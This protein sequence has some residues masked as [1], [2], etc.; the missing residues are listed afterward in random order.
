MAWNQGI[1][2]YGYDDNRFLKGAEY[3]ARW[4]LGKEVPFTPWTWW[5]GAPGVW[6]GSET[7]TT[8]S[9]LGR[10]SVRPIWES[11]HNHY[12]KRRGLAAPHVAAIAA[13]ARPEGSGGDY[14]PNSGGFDQLGFGTLTF[15]RD[16]VPAKAVTAS[17]TQAKSVAAA[18]SASGSA[19]AAVSTE[20]A[21]PEPGTT[22]ALA[23]TD[24]AADPRGDGP[25]IAVA[26]GGV[27]ALA[28]GL[29]ALRRRRSRAADQARTDGGR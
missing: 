7:F 10:G 14:G 1:D 27:V 18:A 6:S 15:T 22:F 8:V 24:S 29:L 16:A 25:I 5:K 21:A 9:P 23:N 28:G 13:K 2:L 3:V 17:P 12:I 26:A 11:I 4:N 19:T 20:S